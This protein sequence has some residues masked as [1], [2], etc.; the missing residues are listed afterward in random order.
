MVSS[1]IIGYVVRSFAI[2]YGLDIPWL[3]HPMLFSS[4]AGISSFLS[5]SSKT[6]IEMIF[7]IFE[8]K[9]L[10]IVVGEHLVVSN[11]LKVDTNLKMVNSP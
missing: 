11:T 7:N 2:K 3:D 5:L 1:V 9:E 10:A 4:A 6:T 8:D